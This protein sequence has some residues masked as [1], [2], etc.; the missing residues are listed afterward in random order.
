MADKTE[1]WNGPMQFNVILDM[2]EAFNVPEK[3]RLTPEQAS[4]FF[5]FVGVDMV[6]QDIQSY[7]DRSHG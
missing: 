4:K 3:D 5:Y 2:P 1:K 7:L 6:Q